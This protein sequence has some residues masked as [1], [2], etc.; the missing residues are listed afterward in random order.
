MILTVVTAS[1]SFPVHE[2]KHAHILLSGGDKVNAAAKA[3]LR[4]SLQGIPSTAETLKELASKQKRVAA[5]KA[6][7]KRR[8]EIPGLILSRDNA[9]LKTICHFPL[10]LKQHQG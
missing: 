4:K 5:K 2:V 7:R 6:A 8:R 9:T 3:R 1:P 10:Q